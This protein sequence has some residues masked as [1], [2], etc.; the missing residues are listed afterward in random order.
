MVSYEEAKANIITFFGF[1]ALLVVL[2]PPVG[3]LV[4]HLGILA[5]KAPEKS[6]LRRFGPDNYIQKKY[7]S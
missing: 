3:I 2:L 5:A 1:C 7:S 6:F 4:T